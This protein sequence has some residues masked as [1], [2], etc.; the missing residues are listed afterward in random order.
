MSFKKCYVRRLIIFFNSYFHFKISLD[1][2]YNKLFIYIITKLRTPAGGL[3][4][5]ISIDHINTKNKGTIP[6][7]VHIFRV[8]EKGNAIC[9][10]SKCCT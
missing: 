10:S 8:K 2:N 1:I 6:S 5:A 7:T 9:F 4:F 3:P